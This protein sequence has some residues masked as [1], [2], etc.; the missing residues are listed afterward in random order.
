VHG[1][2]RAR[3]YKL[4]FAKRAN[5]RYPANEFLEELKNKN[6]KSYMSMTRVLENFQESGPE[7]VTGLYKML[8]GQDGLFE[9]VIFKYR[10]LAFR[11]GDE[12]FLTHGF[13][14]DTDETP[15]DEIERAH[16]IRDEHKAGRGKK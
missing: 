2:E 8:K 3:V 6:R 4:R 9:F 10:I 11:D 12:V 13:K 5:G 15:A 7:G 14:K 16:T 1:G